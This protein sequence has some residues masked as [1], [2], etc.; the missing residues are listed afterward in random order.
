MKN[1]F[2]S[3]GRAVS[4]LKAHHESYFIASCGG[5]TGAQLK[6]YVEN[7]NRPDSLCLSASLRVTEN[8]S[9]RLEALSL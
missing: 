1:D 9:I 3:S 5:V 8:T 7:Q 6:N 2:V 4:E